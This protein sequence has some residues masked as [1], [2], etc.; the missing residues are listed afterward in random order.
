MQIH[1]T[2][3]ALDTPEYA[4]MK[5]RFWYWQGTSGR[6]YIH[7]I[8]EIDACPPLPGAVYVAVKRVGLMRVA[9]AVGRFAP[10]WDK[11]LGEDDLTRLEMLG[12]DEVHVHLLAR[13]SEAAECV[14]QDLTSALGETQMQ[15]GLSKPAPRSTYAH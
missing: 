15:H 4:D 14:K 13:S 3:I 5:Q 10:F 7:S 11:T 8:Y 1:G 9:V 6:K 12:V 2:P